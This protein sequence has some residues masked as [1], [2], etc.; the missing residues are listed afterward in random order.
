ME[1][2]DY[3]QIS[4]IPNLISK[5]RTSFLGGITLPE[6][7]R[8]KQLE[9]LYKLV[10]ENE[11]DWIKAIQSDM[12]NRPTNEIKLT[13]ISCSRSEIAHQIN[14]LT[15]YM[16]PKKMPS[17]VAF[18][19]D[20]GYLHYTPLGNVLIISPWNFPL[21]LTIAPLAGAIAAGCTCI[22]KPS[23]VS[24]NTSALMTRLIPRYLDQKSYCLVTGGPAETT[25]LLK[26]KFD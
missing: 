15:E 13:E 22:I 19:T 23:E 20:S 11:S 21:Q 6:D 5:T 10:N 18:M 4:E 1:K 16:T 2:Q 24:K 8:R 14:N 12:H 26:N 3:T 7:Y 25:V 17:S 9:Q